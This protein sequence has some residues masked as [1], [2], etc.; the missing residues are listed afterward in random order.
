M[1]VVR[2]RAPPRCPAGGPP[3]RMRARRHAAAVGAL[4][5]ACAL[6]A[7]WTPPRQLE[8]AASPGLRHVTPV[9]ATR[10][11]AAAPAP[12]P[13]AESLS[14]AFT[15]DIMFGRFIEHG[16]RAIPAERKS[17]FTEVAAL[18]A[19]DLTLANL[20]T[21]VM[22]APPTTSRWGSTMRF[23]TTP[24]RIATLAPSGIDA[25][26][27]ANN[28]YF[29]MRDAGVTE[30]P[31]LLAAA[32]LHVLGAARAPDEPLFRI[33]TIETAGWSVGLIAAA[34]VNNTDNPD[35]ARL[36]YAESHLIGAA[37]VP[38]ITAARS[39]HDLVIVAVH[40]GIEYSDA[41][42][43]WQIRAAHQWIDAGADA[44]IGHHPH[45]LQAIERYRQGEIAY[46]LG[47]FLFDNDWR[48]KRDS[49]V[50]RLTYRHAPAGQT[51]IAP[52]A[53]VDPFTEGAPT[54]AAAASPAAVVNS[55][56]VCIAD[57][58]FHPTVIEA[59]APAYRPMP[60]ASVHGTQRV[61]KRLVDLSRA[62]RTRWRRSGADLVAAAEC[63]L[64]P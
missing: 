64:T 52:D 36:P 13:P 44:V 10:S 32:G 11:F 29:D 5:A 24:A 48:T 34:T 2:G 63:P 17:P 33:E 47:N 50:L 61:F 8:L 46:S 25:V 55:P 37:L 19:S 57:A 58:R 1:G 16:F 38:L 26:T 49:G 7:A 62:R 41:P 43:R 21:P 51:T 18:L 45:V 3:T 40:W 31:V 20:E 12:P 39:N 35:A 9:A 4:T 28:H 30:T 56:R 23:V 6:T 27:I 59:A 22:T 60:A 53:A 42:E 14:V 15:G 54:T